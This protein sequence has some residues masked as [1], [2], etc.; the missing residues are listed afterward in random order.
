MSAYKALLARVKEDA[1][2]QRRSGLDDLERHLGET[3]IGR[4]TDRT[5]KAPMQRVGLT[6]DTLETVVRRRVEHNDRQRRGLLDL[7]SRSDA[8]IKRIVQSTRNELDHDAT[9]IKTNH[10]DLH[11]FRWHAQQLLAALDSETLEHSL[12]H[13]HTGMTSA[14]TT[15]GL[16]DAMRALFDEINPRLAEAGRHA[17]LM[18]RQLRSTF[19]HLANEHQITLTPPPM[20][21]IFCYQVE[22]NLLEREAEI[23]RNS[24]RTTLMEQHLVTRRFFDTIVT[25]V[26]RIIGA[27]HDAARHWADN[28]TAPLAAQIDACRETLTRRLE[29]LQT[30]AHSR[31]TVQQRIDALRREGTRLQAQTGALKRVSEVLITDEQVAPAQA[32]RQI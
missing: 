10:H 8:E 27:A 23:F 32:T 5:H 19:Q 17:K 1:R 18:R 24:P 12:T 6:F 29:D 26:R 9:H 16:R 22:L 20:L 21:S 25:P 7:A 31:R 4:H 15:N 28:V 3:V 30:T 13:I 2:P 14:W 11:R